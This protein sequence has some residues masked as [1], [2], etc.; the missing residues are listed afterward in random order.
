MPVVP[1]A[2]GGGLWYMV[3]FIER[4]VTEDF[5]CY[6]SMWPFLWGVDFLQCLDILQGCSAGGSKSSSLEVWDFPREHL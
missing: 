1:C 5:I 2:K 4:V 3:F 6:M